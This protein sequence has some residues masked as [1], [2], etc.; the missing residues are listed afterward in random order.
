M[1]RVFTVAGRGQI[2]LSP[3]EQ[4]LLKLIVE[5]K[6]AKEIALELRRSVGGVQSSILH[7]CR[8]LG[9]VGHRAVWGS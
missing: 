8:G 2:R 6:G 7:L 9:V 4:A 1:T 3:S 5:G